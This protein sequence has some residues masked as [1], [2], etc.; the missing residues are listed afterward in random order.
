[1]I[2]SSL[3]RH[4]PRATRLAV[5]SGNEKFAVRRPSRPFEAKRDWLVV[6]LSLQLQ[7]YYPRGWWRYI[8]PSDNK[9]LERKPS[10]FSARWLIALRQVLCLYSS[11]WDQKRL[12][13]R[14][15]GKGYRGQLRLVLILR[16]CPCRR[17]T[18]HFFLIH[19]CFAFFAFLLQARLCSRKFS[20]HIKIEI[21]VLCDLL[22][23]FLSRVLL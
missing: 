2:V 5:K 1:M 7:P 16:A 15:G 23:N 4:I 3:W 18:T 8:T 11:A 12:Q 22:S 6:L 9:L 20:D 13:P 10:V 14:S 19:L 21:V 17:L